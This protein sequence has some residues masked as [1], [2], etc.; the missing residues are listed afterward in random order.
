MRFNFG[1]TT[2]DL[3]FEVDIIG[4]GRYLA[5]VRSRAIHDQEKLLMLAVLDFAVFDFQKYFSSDDPRE[6]ILFLNAEQWIMEDSEWLFSFST[7]CDALGLA[8]GF[9]RQ[10][11]LRWKARELKRRRR[12]PSRGIFQRNAQ[13]HVSSRQ[14][15]VRGM[16]A[17]HRLR[18]SRTGAS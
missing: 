4:P 10:G 9:I 14:N 2:E 6:K 7:I 18:L 12:T 3:L 16:E 17:S 13:I 15:G 5:T 8:P 11:L 1:T